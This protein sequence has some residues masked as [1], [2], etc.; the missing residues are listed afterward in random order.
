MLTT[1]TVPKT[2]P[3]TAPR[4]V[5]KAKTAA[6]EALE[7]TW[8]LKG[9]LKNAQIAYLRVGALLSQVRDKK[10]Y[11]ALD[12][13]DMESY[14]AERLRLGKTSMYRYLQAYDWVCKFHPEWLEPKPAGFIPDLADVA[15]LIRIEEELARPDLA[16]GTKAAL[17]ELRQKGLDGRL[18][19]GEL[20]KLQRQGRGGGQGLKSFLSRLRLLRQQ[21]ARVKDMPAEVI[22]DLD[23]AIAILA[24]NLAAE[25]S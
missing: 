9:H 14:A 4:P 13:K 1:K 23:A 15:D 20:A 8:V 25:R 6:Q 10:L 12:H 16:P 3:A 17:N 22:A 19:E 11:A 18:R 5:A 7:I 21:G 2:A 24:N